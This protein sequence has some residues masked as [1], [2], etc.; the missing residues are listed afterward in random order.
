M[1]KE[2]KKKEKEVLKSKTLQRIQREGRDEPAD[3]GKIQTRW[4]AEY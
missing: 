4:S 3:R 2:E 1:K